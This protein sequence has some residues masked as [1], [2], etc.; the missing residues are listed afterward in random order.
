MN[1]HGI[2]IDVQNVKVTYVA[3]AP[4]WK[5]TIYSRELCN[6]TEDSLSHWLKSA[7]PD[8]ASQSNLSDLAISD[9]KHLMLFGVDCIECPFKLNQKLLS[10]RLHHSFSG[11]IKSGSYVMSRSLALPEQEYKILSSFY[12]MPS[13]GAF[14]ISCDVVQKTGQRSSILRTTNLTK[15]SAANN[16]F[17]RPLGLKRVANESAVLFSDRKIQDLKELFDDIGVGRTK[18]PG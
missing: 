14:P 6:Y 1:Q 11:D 10:M 17:Q 9:G 3:T 12:G 16:V 15:M 2:R 7:R 4:D 18:H 8:A 5:M 13:V